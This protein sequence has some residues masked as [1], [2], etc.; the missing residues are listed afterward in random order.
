MKKISFILMLFFLI[1]S[2][3]ILAQEVIKD[4]GVFIS[5]KNDFYE[6][7]KKGIE[8]FNKKEKKERKV[9]KVDFTGMNLPKSADEFTTYWH[10]EPISQGITGTC[11]SFSTTSMLE[12][13]VYRIHK[14][15]VKLSELWTAYW[16]FV[17]KARGYVQSRGETFFG[18]GSQSNAVYRIIKQYG[19][20]PLDAYNGMLPGQKFHDHSKMFDEMTKYLESVKASNAWSEETVL[21]T[22]KS[23]LNHYI[24]T[25][26]EKVTI[27]GKDYTPKEY[28]SKFV[29]LNLDDYV[30][31]LSLMQQ[32]YYEKVEYEVPDNWWHN[33]DYYNIPLDEF[34]SIL[35][36]SIR[37]G[38]SICIGGDVSEAGMES[39]AEVAII[40][41]FDIPSEY[42]DE[43]SRQFRFSNK[44]TEDDHGIHMV[45]YTEKDGKD[46]YL[47]KDSGAG[48]H[49][50]ANKGYYFYHEDFVKL[51]ML[52][53][54]IHKDA[55]KDILAKFNK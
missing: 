38:Y 36:K 10:N 13:E 4:K 3:S 15:K 54:T 55:V 9:F 17:E 11:W 14:E 45:G 25:P 42:I 8:E 1:N 52:S 34:M 48:A 50:G 20:V 44:T 33:K 40:P 53:F 5:P 29:K 39:K 2:M 21:N 35:K 47:I 18:E 30:E 37:N 51:K 32:P 23:I 16:E 46:W 28:F 7:I 22:I 27:N 31:F 6:E 19:V 41:T 26:P 43:H 24:G 12:S 49:N